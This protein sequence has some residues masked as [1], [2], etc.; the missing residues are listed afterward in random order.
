MPRP[1]N[2]YR[3][4]VLFV[5]ERDRADGALR[6]KFPGL[7]RTQDLDGFYHASA[8]IVRRRRYPRIG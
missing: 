7:E 5:H 3:R 6:S 1:R 8:I 4:T 2:L